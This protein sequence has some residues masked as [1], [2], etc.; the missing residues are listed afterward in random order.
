MVNLSV[1]EFHLTIKVSSRCSSSFPSSE[2]IDPSL[3]FFLFQ[4][5]LGFL[6]CYLGYLRSLIVFLRCFLYV[7]D[8]NN[9]KIKVFRNKNLELNFQW[10]F[11]SLG[12][13]LAGDTLPTYVFSKNIKKMIIGHLSL[14][15]KKLTQPKCTISRLKRPINLGFIYPRCVGSSKLGLCVWFIFFC[16]MIFF[17]LLIL[18][19]NFGFL[20]LFFFSFTNFYDVF[21]K[22][23]FNF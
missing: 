9:F 4:V 15:K 5:D 2:M 17:I 3:R 8:Q 20:W 22:I 16:W 12:A 18:L 14:E 23:L 21:N 13:G 10:P 6:G 19:F 1:N 11:W 7:L